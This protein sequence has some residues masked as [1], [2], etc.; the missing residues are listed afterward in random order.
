MTGGYAIVMRHL[1]VMEVG[2][3][4][5]RGAIT[6]QDSIVLHHTLP[7]ADHDS[8]LHGAGCYMGRCFLSHQCDHLWRGVGSRAGPPY[9]VTSDCE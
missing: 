4:R 3:G 6:E 5:G 7:F 8:Y 9:T 1:R 2:W